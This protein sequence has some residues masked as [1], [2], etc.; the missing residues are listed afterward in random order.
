MN[1]RFVVEGTLVAGLG[2]AAGLLIGTADATRK[3]EQGIIQYMVQQKGDAQAREAKQQEAQQHDL[4]YMLSQGK[5]IL[6][7]IGLPKGYQYGVIS[8]GPANN[9]ASFQGPAS[10]QV[11][12]FSVANRDML[13]TLRNAYGGFL[14]TSTLQEEPS[15]VV[16]AGTGNLSRAAVN[17]LS[18]EFQAGLGGA[19]LKKGDCYVAVLNVPDRGARREYKENS[20][21]AHGRPEFTD[22]L[23]PQDTQDRDVCI[24]LTDKLQK[25]YGLEIIL[26]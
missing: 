11:G 18:R 4:A 9:S 22:T 17:D 3:Y 16:L 13:I 23:T 19:I 21:N 5:D 25:Q 6:A 7:P 1:L 24:E 14:C 10:A 8:F 12:S 2:L 15:I 20:S 26:K